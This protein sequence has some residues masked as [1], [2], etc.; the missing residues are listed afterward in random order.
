MAFYKSKN[1]LA[2]L[3]KRSEE[4]FSVF[5]KTQN[6]CI[7]V[8]NQIAEVIS[9]KE[10]EIKALQEEVSSLNLVRTK[11]GNLAAKIG[12]FLNS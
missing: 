8:N 11:N 2:S 7:E 5:T 3:T 12:T 4:I 1:S 9:G 6:D 10:E